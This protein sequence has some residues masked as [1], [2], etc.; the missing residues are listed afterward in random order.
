MCGI[1]GYTGGKEASKIVFNGLEKLEY[2]GYDSAGIVIN[3]NHELSIIKA[4]GKLNNLAPKLKM[5]PQKGTVGMGHTRWATHGAP[6]ELNAHPHYVDGLAV[7]HNGIIEN[8]QDLKATLTSEGA[9]FKSET[10]TEVVVHLL[11]S[12]IK[13]GISLHDAVF[14]LSKKLVGAFSIGVMSQEEPSLIYLV[15]HGSPMVIGLGEGENFFASDAL[16]LIEYTQK[17]VFLNDG[18]IVKLTPN[19]VDFWDFSGNK[20]TKH[21]TVLEWSASKTEKN[22][23][24]HFMLKEIHEQPSVMANTIQ[25][26][27]NFGKKSINLEQIGIDKIDLNLVNRIHIVAC[28]TSYYAGLV[29]KYSLEKWARIPVEVELASE[30]RYRDPCVDKNTLIIPISQSG[31]TADTLACVKYA[32]TMGSQIL[33]ICNVMYSSI[34]RES[35]TTLYME[36][37][38][39]IGVAST[40]AFTSM[41]LNLYLL[42][43]GLSIQL[44]RSNKEMIERT[45]EALKKFPALVDQAVECEPQINDISI[46]Y[47][48][49]TNCIFIGRGISFP[50][51][52]EGSLKLK[53]I[54]YIHAEGY[55]GGEL[56]HGPIAL[57]DRHMPVVAIAPRD[58]DREKMISN[59][60]EVVARDG[61]ILGIGHEDDTRFKNLCAHYI[62]CPHSDDEVLQGILSVI[63]TQLLSYHVAVRR[64]TDV[65]QPRNLAKSVTVE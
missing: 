19:S 51:A 33:A 15:K 46:H 60:E 55:A 35:N 17:V 38:P 48:E 18:E 52:L 64:G 20:L 21:A 13:K 47:Y 59:I 44:N 49:A 63:P 2:R 1:I 37:G 58:K 29:A 34:P 16:V 28:G 22:G 57:I 36:A 40:K 53:E 3:Y 32:K 12:D 65:D 7:I 10:D 30:F 27:C 50:I 45:F 4:E 8:Y 61:K 54:S 14:G 39:E 9:V 41:I 6:T 43:I 24:K 25:R 5:L 56:K 62:N 11:N 31:E 26:L 42:S 23:F